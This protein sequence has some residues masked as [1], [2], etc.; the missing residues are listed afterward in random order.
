ML[1]SEDIMVRNGTM[2]LQ[3]VIWGVERN[4]A[5]RKKYSY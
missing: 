1:I 3:N 4:D 2:S 5:K